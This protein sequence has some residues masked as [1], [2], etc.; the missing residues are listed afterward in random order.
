[1]AYPRSVAEAVEV[2]VEVPRF[3]RPELRGCASRSAGAGSEQPILDWPRGCEAQQRVVTQVA[4]Y[5]PFEQ[6]SPQ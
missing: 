6:L 3:Y 2:P 4:W 1:V 5:G